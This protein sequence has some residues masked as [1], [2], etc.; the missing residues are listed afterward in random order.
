MYNNK[1]RPRKACEMLQIE[2]FKDDTLKERITTIYHEEDK[3]EIYEIV[4]IL[5]LTGYTIKINYINSII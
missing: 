5:A 1:L 4:N 2:V 3:I